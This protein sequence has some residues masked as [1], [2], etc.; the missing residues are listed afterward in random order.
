MQ[1]IETPHEE[2]TDAK[3]TN[4]EVHACSAMNSL[5]YPACNRHPFNEGELRSGGYYKS[6]I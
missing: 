2:R 5:N 4:K 3:I 6:E 1:S